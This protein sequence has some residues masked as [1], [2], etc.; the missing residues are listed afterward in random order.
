MGAEAAVPRWRPAPLAVALVLCGCAPPLQAAE[1]GDLPLEGGGTLRGLR[2]G[3]R[4]F[5]RMDE[6]RSNVVLVA[7]WLLGT[8]RQVA[9]QIGPGGLVDSSRYFVV[10]VDGIANGVS[11]SP[12]NSALQPG[13]AFPRVSIRDQVESQ[14]RLVTEV[15]GVRRLRGVV[16]VSFGAVQAFEW[17]AAFPELVERVVAVAGTPG[18]EEG[19]RQRW[20]TEMA[21]F[22]AS[23][24]W[25]RAWSALRRGAVR[26]ALREASADPEDY[27]RQAEALVSYGAVARPA[28]PAPLGERLLVV[29]SQ[30]DPVLDPGPAR[31]LAGR[32]GARL[33]VLDGRCGHRAPSCERAVLWPAI[34][35]FLG[36]ASR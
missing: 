34:N 26:D 20:R 9:R 6:A 11:T 2:L 25:R 5:G 32:A 24:P 27:L 4:T 28:T 31:A 36:G 22:H 15:L 1:L 13:A 8:S 7:P 16:G 35:D 29:V 10:A 19:E 23:P 14:R 30:A 3:Y 12:S 21:R 17:Q 33:L 18:L